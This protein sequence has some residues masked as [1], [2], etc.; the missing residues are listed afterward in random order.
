MQCF[1]SVKSLEEA[2][3]L[4]SAV[5]LFDTH[6]VA[7]NIADLFNKCLPLSTYTG[8]N[9][10]FRAHFRSFMSTYIP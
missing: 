10:A 4:A 5:P 8:G 7:E 1:F 9:D 3:I 2:D 6:C